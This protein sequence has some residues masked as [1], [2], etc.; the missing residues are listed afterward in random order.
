MN[1]YMAIVGNLDTILSAIQRLRQ[2][3]ITKDM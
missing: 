3:K 2:K 1:K